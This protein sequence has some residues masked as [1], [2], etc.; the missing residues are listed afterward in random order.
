MRITDSQTYG[1][2]VEFRILGSVEILFFRQIFTRNT[3][4]MR[5][6]N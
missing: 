4:S 1:A 6:A 5:A 3:R 2:T